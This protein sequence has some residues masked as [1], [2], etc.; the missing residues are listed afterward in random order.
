MDF[1]KSIAPWIATAVTG[2]VPALVGMA[3]NE[4][5]EALGYEVQ[6]EPKAIESAVYSASAEQ[7]LA[8]KQADQAFEIKMKELGYSHIEKLEALAVDD[9]KSAREREISIK[10]W[11]PKVLATVVTIGY[12]GVLAYMLQYGVP[13]EGGEALLVMLGALGGGWGSVL[14][15]YYGSSSGSA[16]K[17]ELL[18]RSR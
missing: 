16:A 8:I 17:N 1:L 9:R 6:P 14:A 12:F 11:T 10:D 15:Y 5:S 3:A 7:L 4:I 18:T 13:K 2:G